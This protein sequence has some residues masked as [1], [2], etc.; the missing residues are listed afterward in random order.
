MT[1]DCNM[2]PRTVPGTWDAPCPLTDKW[3]AD[4]DFGISALVWVNVDL[5]YVQSKMDAL[6]YGRPVPDKWT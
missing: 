1:K 3:P 6:M 4:T 2:F 5:G